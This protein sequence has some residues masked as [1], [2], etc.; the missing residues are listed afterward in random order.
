MDEARSYL[1]HAVF[2]GEKASN[3]FGKMSRIFAIRWGVKYRAL[4]VLYSGTY[5]AI[6]MYA[7]AVWCRCSSTFVVK[8]ALLRT[9]RPALTL[10]TKA[11]RSCSTAVL[12]VLAGILPVDL[13]VC[14]AGTI[15]EEQVSTQLTPGELRR[16]KI[17]GKRGYR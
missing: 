3:C 13:E 5:V 14:R 7:A 8:R 12:T 15:K 2:I 4:R 9:Q 17:Q 11:Y 16:L 1:Q 6:V 10:L